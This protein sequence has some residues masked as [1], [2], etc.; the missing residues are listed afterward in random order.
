MTEFSQKYCLVQFL[1]PVEDGFTFSAKDWPLHSTIA[2]VFAI[3]RR[4]HGESLRQTVA[5]QKTTSSHTT[6]PADFGPNGEVPVML[7]ERTA[8]LA[9]LH[10]NIVNF[11]LSHDG[12]FNEPLYLHDDFRPHITIHGNDVPP[13]MPVTFDTL[14]L[15]DMFPGGDHTL[16]RVLATIALQKA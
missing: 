9:R 10:S 2:E 5:A 4:Q 11:V 14:S 15:V 1:E 13:N 6:R 8:E 12:L 3:D 7:V 16:R